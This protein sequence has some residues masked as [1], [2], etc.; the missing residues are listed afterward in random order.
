MWAAGAAFCCQ[1][2]LHFNSH[3]PVAG[4]VRAQMMMLLHGRKLSDRRVP[5]WQGDGQTWMEKWK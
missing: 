2:R 1:A 5:R 4:G 3:A